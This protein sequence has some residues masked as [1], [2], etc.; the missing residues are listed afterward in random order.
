M[1]IFGTQKGI[2]FLAKLQQQGDLIDV[3]SKS[4]FDRQP[5]AEDDPN[6]PFTKEG[7]ERLVNECANDS[8]AD[9]KPL[10]HLLMIHIDDYKNEIREELIDLYKPLGNLI[11]AGKHNPDF[12]IVNLFT[13]QI[14]CVGLGRKNR[15][16]VI[17]ASTGESFNAPRLVS[18][19]QSGDLT[20]DEAHD[21][22]TQFTQHD[23]Y[24]C[25][26]VL[27]Q[28]LDKLGEAMLQY[29]MLP[30]EE[31]Y[32]EHTLDSGPNE[33]GV[34]QLKDFSGGILDEKEYS[35]EYLTKCLKQSWD[36]GAEIDEALEVINL[37]FPQ[38]EHCELN[39]FDF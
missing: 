5:S 11:D 32:I 34:Y 18:G 22:I 10:G 1:K 33:N 24:N 26:S 13:Q 12:L 39:T 36:Y 4:F 29:G 3:Y 28:A 19:M 31:D 35:G 8:D 20:G 14:L 9:C 16:F 38:C 6:A 15:L 25:V 17:D 27:L 37:F 23:V 21:Y 2:A 7:F 30:A